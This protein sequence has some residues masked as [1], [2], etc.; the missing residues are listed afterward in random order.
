MES[1]SLKSFCLP[2]RTGVKGYQPQCTENR[3]VTGPEN[4]LY[5]RLVRTLFSPEILQAVAVKGLL[6]ILLITITI[7]LP[8][9][10]KKKKISYF[11]QHELLG[12]CRAPTSIVIAPLLYYFISDG[13]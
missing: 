6:I 7:T 1:D 10:K 11:I 3:S 8:S 5:C 12:L 9:C 13:H 2:F 4:V